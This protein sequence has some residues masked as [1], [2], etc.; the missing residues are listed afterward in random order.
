MK[1]KLGFLTFACSLCLLAGGLTFGV[2]SASASILPIWQGYNLAPGT[3]YTDHDLDYYTPG[4]NN[5]SGNIQQGDILTSVLVFED[6]YHL[7]SNGTNIYTQLLNQVQHGDTTNTLVALVTLEVANVNGTTIFM[8]QNGNTPMVQFYQDS[9]VS[10][11]NDPSLA[12]AIADA[13]NGTHLWDFSTTNNPNTFWRFD[14]LSSASLTPSI[15]QGVDSGALV[16]TVNFALD[17]VDGLGRFAPMFYNAD[18]FYNTSA[19]NSL[20][21]MYGHAT[22]SGGGGLTGAFANSN[23]QTYLNPVPEPTTMAL[24]GFGLMGL[25][26]IGRR[27]SRK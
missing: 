16:G 15:I 25:G 12:T 5:S 27:R 17:E 19:T 2:G 24:F 20:V 14:G 22:I 13:T 26:L 21:D 11:E 7:A 23:A 10:L 3:E 1:L 4:A 6:A 9:T 18:S 8:G